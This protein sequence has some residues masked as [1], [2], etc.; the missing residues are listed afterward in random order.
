[1]AIRTLRGEVVY[2]IDPDEQADHDLQP[3]LESL[4]DTRRIL[5]L[6]EDGAPSWW[7]R[8]KSILRGEPVMA[9][10]LVTDE[11]AAVGEVIEVNVRETELDDVY[12]AR[13]P[14]VS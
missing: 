14:E 4:A 7:E 10:T 3:A 9:V 11:P 8:A 1:M 5:V 2:A 12:V 13:D 6:R